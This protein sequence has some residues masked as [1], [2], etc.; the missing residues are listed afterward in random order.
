MIGVKQAKRKDK[1][2]GFIKRGVGERKSTILA[3]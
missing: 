3:M 2:A 1:V